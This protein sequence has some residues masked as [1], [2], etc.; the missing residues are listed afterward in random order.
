MI[1]LRAGDVVLAAGVSAITTL[2]AL[3]F[4]VNDNF[5]WLVIA[6]TFGNLSGSA[7][8]RG[9]FSSVEQATLAS[10]TSDANPPVAT[11]RVEGTSAGRRAVLWMLAVLLFLG[12]ATA[13]FGV[14]RVAAGRPALPSLGNRAAWGTGTNDVVLIPRAL[15]ITEP[16]GTRPAR[17]AVSVP[18]G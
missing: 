7:R 12:A 15:Q 14:A 9:S 8:D 4:A 11:R 1:P 16:D 2:G 6:A 18:Q 10:A 3:A 5:W 17:F 13:G